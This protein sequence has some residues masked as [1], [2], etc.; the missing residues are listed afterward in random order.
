MKKLLAIFLTLALV[1]GMAAVPAFADTT[2]KGTISITNYHE[3]VDYA[4]YRLLDLE[5][6]DKASGAYSYKA[7]DAWAGF[8]ATDA[9]KAYITFDE[10]GYATWATG[11]DEASVA[12]FGKLA[13]DYAKNNGID[14][15]KS[16]LNE[17]EMEVVNSGD[18]TYGKFTNLPMG[19]YLVDTTMGA[20]CG[21]TT[22]NPDAVVNAKN[23][24]PTIDKQVKEDSTNQYGGENTADIGQIVEYRL[25]INVHAG[26]ENYVLH[27]MMSE[28]LDFIGVTGIEHVIPS[29]NDTNNLTLGEDYTVATE[30]LDE[31]CTFEVRFSNAFCAQLKTND[32][33]IVHYTARLNPKA[34][35]AGDGNSNKATLTY[36]DKHVT[37][38]DEVFTHTYSIDIVKTDSQNTLLNGAQFRIYDAATGGNEVK[39]V[40]MSDGETYRRAK[41]DEDGEAI[42]VE[43]GKVTVIGFDNGTYYLEETVSPTGYN[44][45]TSRQSFTISD[46][47]LE[48]DFVD[49]IYSTGTGVH[50]VNKTGSMLPETGGFGTTMFI[51]LGGLAVM[52]AGIFLFVNKRMSQIA[53]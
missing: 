2:V 51:I 44:K 40:L 24:V 38:E 25:T 34:V 43:N 52:A 12:A 15:V 39:V 30:D 37:T 10:A 18:K 9:A 16:S 33:V 45:L 20:L 29:T 46:A 31:G 1:L 13:L 22:T 11:E 28:G 4:I 35:V 53:E 47:N 27:D 48:A 7:N 17:D 32:K 26:A 14:P 8:F 41:D 49:D 36:G 19:Y 3:D 50:V 21:L 42:V 23:G 5:S 6:Y